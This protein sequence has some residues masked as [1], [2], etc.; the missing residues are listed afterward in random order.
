MVP[1]GFVSRRCI[2][3]NISPGQAAGI[4]YAEFQKNRSGKTSTTIAIP[5]NLVDNFLL[6]NVIKPS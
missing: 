2:E 3:E 1:P 6:Y 4:I 5:A